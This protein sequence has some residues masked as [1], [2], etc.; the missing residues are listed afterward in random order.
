[1][2]MSEPTV[3]SRHGHDDFF[4]RASVPRRV[5]RAT[6]QLRDVIGDLRTRPQQRRDLGPRLGGPL[7]AAAASAARSESR[8]AARKISGSLRRGG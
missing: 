2:A 4:R 5:T 1:M 7:R 3:L 6:V 8:S